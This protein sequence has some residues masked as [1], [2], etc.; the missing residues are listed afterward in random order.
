MTHLTDEELVDLLDG[1]LPDQ[2][3]AHLRSCGACREQAESLG[4]LLGEVAAVDVPEPS[5]LFWDH[6]SRRVA[7]AVDEPLPAPRGWP[8]WLFRPA[9]AWAAA[10]TSLALVAALSFST[11]PTSQPG[12]GGAPNPSDAR[13]HATAI[14][15]EPDDIDADEGWALVRSLADEVGWDEAHAAGLSPG[16]EAAERIALELSSREQSE[17]A[18]LLQ[19]ELKRPGA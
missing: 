1:A 7:D 13:Q 16:P 10:V 11:R 5:P 15:A 3:R 9:S 2:R 8:G 12:I 17:L 19:A 18:L 6:L 14:A 4:T